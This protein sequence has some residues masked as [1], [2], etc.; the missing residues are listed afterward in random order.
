MMWK[1]ITTLLLNSFR[2]TFEKMYQNLTYLIYLILCL[3]V[4]DDQRIRDKINFIVIGKF[5]N[6]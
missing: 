6:T 2:K 5:K 1:C 3:C 4:C